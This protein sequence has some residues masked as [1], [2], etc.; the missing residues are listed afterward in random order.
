VQYKPTERLSLM[1]GYLFNT[2]PIR[3]PETL[4]NAQ[5]PAIIQH[6]LSLGATYRVTDDVSFSLAWQHGFRNAI[7]GPIGQV[8]GSSIRLDAQADIIYTGLTIQY[9]GK[10]AA[11]TAPAPAPPAAAVA[12]AGSPE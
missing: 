8:P 10:K 4:F 12:N 6:L 11:A 3:S 5:A 1:G 2:N 9:G 7:E